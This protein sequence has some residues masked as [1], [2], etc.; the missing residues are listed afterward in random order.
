MGADRRFQLIHSRA[1][2]QDRHSSLR[3][4]TV[5]DPCTGCSSVSQFTRHP[6]PYTTSV[7]VELSENVF[8][9]PN[10]A[11]YPQLLLIWAP[12]REHSIQGTF[13]GRMNDEGAGKE[14]WHTVIAKLLML[15]GCEPFANM[16]PPVSSARPLICILD[17]RCAVS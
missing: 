8:A 4:Q 13:L 5:C 12:Y 1:T 14:N 2:T 17:K 11:K 10:T 3:H 15:R 6:K 16:R 7:W 9:R